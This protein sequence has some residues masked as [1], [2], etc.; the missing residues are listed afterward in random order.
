[1]DDTRRLAILRKQVDEAKGGQPDNLE[2]WRQRTDAALRTAMGPTHPTVERF[3][4]VSYSVGVYY[5]G[6]P[7]HLEDDARRDGV[8][9]GIAILQGAI[10]E[11]EMRSPE[12]PTATT[13]SRDVRA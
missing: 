12:A 11:I 5:S 2:A 9:T 8:Q 6:M 3:N 4:N 13:R 7:E 10:A 1:M